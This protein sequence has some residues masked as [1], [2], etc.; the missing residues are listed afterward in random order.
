[1]ANPWDND[2]IVTADAPPWAKDPVVSG[3]TTFAPG[4]GPGYAED[5]AK[6]AAPSAVRMVTGVAGLPGTVGGGSSGGL[7][8]QLVRGGLRMA[9]APNIP[10]EADAPAAQAKALGGPD[11]AAPSSQALN[12]TVEQATGPLYEAQTYPGKITSGIIENAPAALFPGGAGARLAQAAVPAVA[13]ATVDQLGGGPLAQAAAALAGGIGVTKTQKALAARA[14]RQ[15]APDAA[16]LDAVATPNYQQL[17]ATGNTIPVQPSIP[18]T[19]TTPAIVG[20]GERMADDIGAMLHPLKL[21]E[22]NA[23]RTYG[24]LDKLKEAKDLNDISIARDILR[25][26]QHGITDNVLTKIPG[27][28]KRAAKLAKE[29]LDAEMEK[30]S[31]GW[32][33]K[34]AETDSNWAAKARLDKLDEYDE[35]GK[36]LTA[37]NKNMN[38]TKGFT[39][40]ELAAITKAGTGGKLGT[41]L[42]KVGAAA[43]PLHGGLS[44]L[45][46]A[47]TAFGTGGASIPWQIAAAFGGVGADLGVKALKSKALKDANALLGQRSHLGQQQI[48]APVQPLSFFKGAGYAAP[49]ILADPMQRQA[50]FGQD[51]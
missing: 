12:S 33:A 9:G 46:H 25:D 39:K 43:N 47:A 30:L 49:G 35:A 8:G 5:I 41:V 1:M 50:L 40:E 48:T 26:T 3:D 11:I 22:A 4:E 29:A 51:Y 44:S 7:I 28:D 42:D 19:K 20:D 24:Q 6:S 15:A 37:F 34:N 17:T 32:V 2:P 10:S 23:K 38:R 45:V 21:R 13:S 16:A 36:N 18:K 31:P 27:Q 14:A